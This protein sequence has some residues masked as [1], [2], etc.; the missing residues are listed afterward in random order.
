MNLASDASHRRTAQFS[1][2]NIK[3]QVHGNVCYGGDLRGPRD[4]TDP[5]S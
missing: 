2:D 4:H 1:I 3:R 5:N